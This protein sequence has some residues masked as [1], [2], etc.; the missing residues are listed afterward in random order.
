MRELLIA[1]T[2]E[3]KITEI[4]AFLE[5]MPFSFLSLS[6]LK[7][8]IPAPEEVGETISE[9]ALLKARYYAQKSGMLTLADDTGLFIGALQGWPGIMS[10]RVAPTS[11]EQTALTLEKMT[12]VA[13]DKRAA[14]FECVTALVDPDS[15]VEFLAHGVTQGKIL[16]GA[17]Q[18][19]NPFGYDPI[20]YIPELGK[21]YTELTTVEKNAVS[22]RGKAL[23]RIKHHLQNTYVAKHIVVPFALIIKDGKVLMNLRN[24]PHR[25]EYHKKWEFP[26]G[27]VEF[28]E[29]MHGNMIREVKEEVGYDVE[30]VRLLQHIAVESQM[31]K[32]YAYQ[33]FLVPYVCRIVGGNGKFSDGE[34]LETRW[35]ELDNVLDHELIGENA[36]MYKEF[37]PELKE[38]TKNFNL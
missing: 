12:G 29:S 17:V 22:H 33:V 1:T 38:V 26:G 6:D 14:H 34:V 15:N 21:T 4:K 20:F 13:D 25:P 11:K 27:K 28:G 10:A 9:N 18:H 19:P 7:E 31:Q 3:H 37:L 5:H 8:S 16:S 2:N 32:T 23:I 30:I 35:F 24:D 36:R